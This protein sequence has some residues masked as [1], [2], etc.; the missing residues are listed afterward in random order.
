MIII[1]NNPISQIFSS[2][3]HKKPHPHPKHIYT[4]IPLN[5]NLLFIFTSLHEEVIAFLFLHRIQTLPYLVSLFSSVVFNNPSNFSRMV[6]R[7]QASLLGVHI[8]SIW[9]NVSRDHKCNNINKGLKI[10]HSKWSSV[11]KWVK[12]VKYNFFNLCTCKISVIFLWY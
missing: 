1:G 9:Q 5:I 10:R 6:W 8:K 12:Y 2:L 11:Q 4:S 7:T 3:Y